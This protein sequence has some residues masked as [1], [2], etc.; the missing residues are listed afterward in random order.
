MLTRI[1]P[2]S[3][4]GAL[5]LHDRPLEVLASEHRLPV[6]LLTKYLL[7]LCRRPIS[8]SNLHYLD[9]RL[10]GLKTLCEPLAQAPGLA[11][12]LQQLETLHPSGLPLRGDALQKA[13]APF[14]RAAA[15]HPGQTVLHDG[16]PPADFVREARRVLLVFGPGIGIGDEII[17]F[18][19]PRWLRDEQPDLELTVLSAYQGLWDRVEGVSEIRRYIT[20]G[21]L[22]KALRGEPPFDG[23]DFVI[24]GEFEAPGLSAAIAGEARLERFLEISLGGR[25][26]VAFDRERDSLYRLPSPA[27][28]F[29]GYYAFLD[30]QLRQL[31]LRPRQRFD[32]KVQS[33]TP[34]GGPLRFFVT[35]FTSKYEP[36]PAYW[37]HLLAGLAECSDR[38]LH[39][40]LD[41][42]VSSA[43]RRFAA[44]LER[45]V[46]ARLPT[47]TS[48]DKARPDKGQRLSIGGLLTDLERA[49]VVLCAD[50]FTAHAG[51]QLDCIT[52]VVAPQ[53]LESWQVPAPRNFYFSAEQRVRRTVAEMSMAL[54][55]E[56]PAP[57]SA[58]RDRLRTLVET[59]TSLFETGATEGLEALPSLYDEFLALSHRM[60]QQ[61]GGG[62][63]WNEAQGAPDS[64]RSVTSL[65]VQGGTLAP[66]LERHLWDQLQRWCNSNL[67]K[68]LILRTEESAS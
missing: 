18:P 50:S 23:F 45:S 14:A 35:P 5:P 2:F 33:T 36:S 1:T 28:Y 49:H 57:Q 16:P 68:S 58:D 41:I 39:F 9:S 19:L 15:Q 32:G 60:V 40:V 29:E 56:T 11:P 20:H 48:V 38:P 26:V 67:A 46:R 30:W 13:L 27:P 37:S 21:E 53:G 62:T 3:T 52:L 66:A 31:G 8:Q 24:L 43:T 54:G 6:L 55:F 63:L 17:F 51:A 44:E 47:G 7:F 4:K 61:G 65:E 34:P 10:R 22:L 42:G 64:L 59:L 12:V 25:S